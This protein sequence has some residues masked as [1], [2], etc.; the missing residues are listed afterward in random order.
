MNLDPRGAEF[1]GALFNRTSDD[2]HR[3]DVQENFKALNPVDFLNGKPWNS[4]TNSTMMVQVGS[5]PTGMSRGTCPACGE[6]G[7]RGPMRRL[8]S[9]VYEAVE[10]KIQSQK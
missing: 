5:F 8:W 3:K 7:A 2:E 10:L 9:Y 1:G 4:I 6:D